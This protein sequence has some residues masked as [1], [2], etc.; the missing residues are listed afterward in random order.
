[1]FVLIDCEN[2]IETY[3]FFSSG[4]KIT[5]VPRSQSTPGA[6]TEDFGKGELFKGL[7]YIC[8]CSS[9]ESIMEGFNSRAPK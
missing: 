5:K 2:S 9:K 8:F 1:M 6:N 3:E 4:T 7:V